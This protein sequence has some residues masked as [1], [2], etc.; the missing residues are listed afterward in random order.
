MSR[1]LST[2]VALGLLASPA[3]AREQ[4]TD[5]Q[6]DKIVAG[7]TET[8]TFSINGVLVT[9][10]GTGATVSFSQSGNSVTVSASSP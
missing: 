7:D 6:L 4:L 1:V 5:Q 9:A 8:M 3:L 10:T 2:I